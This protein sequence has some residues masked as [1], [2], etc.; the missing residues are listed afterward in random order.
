ML[1]KHEQFLELY[2]EPVIALLNFWENIDV[3]PN[4]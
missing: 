4:L 3:T 2:I 1:F